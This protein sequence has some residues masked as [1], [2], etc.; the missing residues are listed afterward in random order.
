MAT[1]GNKQFKLPDTPTYSATET[2]LIGKLVEARSGGVVGVAAA[3]SVV[4]LGVAEH[5]V[6]AADAGTTSEA[7]GTVIT[8]LAQVG[9]Y[10]PYV[11]VGVGIFVVQY[12]AA[13]TFGAALKAAA[14]GAVTPWVSGTDAA[15]LIVGRCVQPG[16][17]SG[18]GAALARI[19]G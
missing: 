6:L 17:V 13:A 18:A 14:S 16:G 12:A 7:D 19:T 3:G 15:N 11:S 8:D 10:N 9:P 2:I 1:V 5:S 4:V